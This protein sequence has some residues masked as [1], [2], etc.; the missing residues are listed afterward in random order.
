MSYRASMPGSP[1]VLALPGSGGARTPEAPG[2]LGLVVPLGVAILLALVGVARAEDAL[3]ATPDAADAPT[4]ESGPARRLSADAARESLAVQD[5]ATQDP[6][7]DFSRNG[8]WLGLGGGLALENF[9]L[10]G[11]YDDAVDIA[12]RAGYRG[13]PWLAVEM[14]GEVLTTF[15]GKDAPNGDVDGFLVS[16]NARAI[17]PLGRVEPWLMAGLGVLDVDTDRSSRQEDFAF[18]SAAGVDLY[19][20]PSWV[21]YGEASYLLPTGDVDRFDYAT[22]GAGILFRF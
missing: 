19:L 22:F 10:P 9:S 18:R 11:R 2:R 17:A 13:M 12:F 16:L 1:A 4:E 3:R 14:L 8:A 21:L 15:D 20:N 5:G 6:E 7:A